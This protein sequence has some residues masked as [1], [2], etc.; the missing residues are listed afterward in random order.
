MRIA[1][2][3]NARVPW[4]TEN[5]VASSLEELGHEVIKLQEGEVRAVEVA[6]LVTDHGADLFLWTQTYNLAEAGGT[7]E[8][9]AGMLDA[10]KANGV[11]TVAFHL[12]RYWGLSREHQIFEE[13]WFQN[14]DFVFSAD[15]GNQE[16]F[17][18][19]G[20]NHYW[21][22][23]AVYGPECVQGEPKGRY[24]ADV[25]FVG[26]SRTY[27]PEWPWRQE[28]IAMLQEEYGRRF[29]LWPQGRSVRGSNLS[30]LYASTKVV[31]GDSCFAGQCRDYWSDRVAET[32]GRGGF[33]LFPRVDGLEA[34]FIDGEHLVLYEAGDAAGLKALIDRWL[35]DPEGRD[36]I[37]LAG[38]EHVKAHHTYV[39]RMQEMLG[40]L[41]PGLWG[42]DSS[43]VREIFE[44]NVYRW[45]PSELPPNPVVVDVGANVGVFSSLALQSEARVVAVEP[46]S[47]NVERLKANLDGQV[48]LVAAAMGQSGAVDVKP[49]A[50]DRSN[51]TTAPGTEVRSMTLTELMAEC[52]LDHIDFLKVDCEGCEYE[53][54]KEAPLDRVDR[55]AMEFHNAPMRP[56]D[57]FDGLIHRLA[58]YGHVEILGRPSV[59]GYIFWRRY[60]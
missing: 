49:G 5:H 30:D 26:S 35:R 58:E 56:V 6:G 21:L 50:S 52:S 51:A 45:N 36:R 8:E 23:P 32:L 46:F 16:R 31:V 18:E 47:E 19:A 33:L 39:H 57:D 40:V 28:L 53:M 20:V 25:A 37:R 17:Q 44:E 12:D 60:E 7:R 13:P 9:R 55:I 54:F 11:P 59:G 4:T 14:C 10:L 41:L 24:K 38:H 34:D 15:G 2:L 42:A 3:G 29:R 48:M 1:Y 27:H 22:K 43:I